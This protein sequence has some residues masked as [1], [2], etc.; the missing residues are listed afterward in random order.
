MYAE[1]SSS[2]F[3]LPLPLLVCTLGTET[4][5]RISKNGAQASIRSDISVPAP[6]EPLVKRQPEVESASALTECGA[7]QADPIPVI[8]QPPL[9]PAQSQELP[10]HDEEDEHHGVDEEEEQL[11]RAIRESEITAREEQAAANAQARE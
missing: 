9:V 3:C 2:P 5:E 10:G 6:T 8:V 11:K 7:T 4:N 1:P